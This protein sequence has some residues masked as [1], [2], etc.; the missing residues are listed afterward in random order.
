MKAPRA[1]EGP[2]NNARFRGGHHDETATHSPAV[3]RQ[4]Q[5]ATGDKGNG[6]VTA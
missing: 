4:I 5:A 3:S 1:G 6:T 2:P